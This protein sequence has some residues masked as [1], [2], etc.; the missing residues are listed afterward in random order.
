MAIFSIVEE[1]I[2]FVKSNKILI[3]LT[4]INTNI[5]IVLTINYYSYVGTATLLPITIIRVAIV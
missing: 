5:L 3:I 4:E 1:I 2:I